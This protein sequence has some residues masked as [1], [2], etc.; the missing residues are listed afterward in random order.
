MNATGGFN[1]GKGVR[2]SNQK[3]GCQ[4]CGK[5]NHTAFY[6]YHRQNLQFQPPPFMPP[7]VGR[8]MS[9]QWNSGGS[10]SQ[11]QYSAMSPMPQ[12]NTVT[13]SPRYHDFNGTG[14]NY[15]SSVNKGQFMGYSQGFPQ[16]VGYSSVVG[17]SQ[18][19]PQS[20]GLS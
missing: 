6:Y 11:G 20:T 14:Y 16:S 5:S 19:F 4:I 17:Y 18:G 8:P 2:R 7:P 1:R 3:V 15:G 12:A 10:L 9:N 13:L